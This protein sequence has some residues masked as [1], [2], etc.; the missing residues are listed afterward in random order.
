MAKSTDN[1][2]AEM[3]DQLYSFLKDSLLDPLYWKDVFAEK[4]VTLPEQ[5]S[6]LEEDDW[7]SF[8]EKSRVTWERKVI[9]KIRI[10]SQK[11]LPSEKFKTIINNHGLE[12]IYWIQVFNGIGVTTHQQLK[13]LHSD[14]WDHLISMSRSSYQNEKAALKNL[15]RQTQEKSVSYLA[16]EDC[17]N[18]DKKIKEG[19]LNRQIVK[20]DN[21]G[22]E[23]K[24]IKEQ[25]NDKNTA[26]SLDSCRK[27][28]NGHEMKMSNAT[29]TAVSIHSVEMLQEILSK[30][31]SGIIC[32]GFYIS[33]DGGEKTGSQ[34]IE[35]CGQLKLMAPETKRKRGRKVIFYKEGIR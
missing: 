25:M 27:V 19:K 21:L 3:K 30:A 7:Q 22:G 23:T 11:H 1:Q 5:L 31:S 13:H 12:E 4:H 26:L 28:V 8:K 32:R 18:W 29:T 17:I 15:Q 16:D 9:E 35:M 20:C 2:S 33:K 24:I 10:N 34:A 6:F 14:A